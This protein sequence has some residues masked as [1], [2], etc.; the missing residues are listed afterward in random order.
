MNF[1]HNITQLENYLAHKGY[2]GPYQNIAAEGLIFN[3]E[4]KLTLVL[5]GGNARDE[6]FKL[7]GIGGRVKPEERADFPSALLREIEEEIGAKPGDSVRL[8]IKIDQMLEVRIVQFHQ[9]AN[10]EWVNWVVL[11]YLCRIEQGLPF[12]REPDK[13]LEI[14]YLSLDE[15]FSW[16]KEPLFSKS[17]ELESPGLSKS[18]VMGRETYKRLYGNRPYYELAV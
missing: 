18:L 6:Q 15:L 1:I 3:L 9:T 11:S 12:N 2:D 5:R 10:G 7:E 14:K 17:G 4:G 13:H 8:N 16:N